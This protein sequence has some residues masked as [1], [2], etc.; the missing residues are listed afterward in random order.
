MNRDIPMTEEAD[1]RETPASLFDPLHTEFRFT[2]DACATHENA[3]CSLY[4]TLTGLYQR[5]RAHNLEDGCGL[6]GSW[7]GA[8][9]WCNPP[10]SDIGSWVLKAWESDAAIVV[11]LVPATRCEQDWWQ[12][13]VEPFRD[14]KAGPDGSMLH[15]TTRFLPG[16]KHFLEDGKPIYRKNKDGS[17]WLSKKGKPA[18]S[19][20]KFG[21]V[22]LIWR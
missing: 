16:R 2:L 14:G 15:L 13:G 19:S 1:V 7:R 4:Y 10:Y 8:R 17:I 21:C 6:S 22:L 12:L 11:M 9:V 20:P 18:R 5:D 3:K